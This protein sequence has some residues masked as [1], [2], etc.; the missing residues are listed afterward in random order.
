[1][2]VFIYPNLKKQYSF[3]C[4]QEV[5]KILS[6]LDFNILLTDYSGIGESKTVTVVDSA[7]EAVKN[8]D[9]II[10]IGGDGTILKIAASAA[11]NNKKLLGINCG[12]LGFMASMERGE[13]CYLSK[14]K[15]GSYT[16]ESR[17]MLDA[18]VERPSGEFTA[19]TA[20]NDIVITHGF[21]YNINDFTVLADG[22]TV[23]SLRADG[24]IFST[25]TGASAYSL[26]AGGP[27]I[28]PSMD[29]IEFTQICPHSLFARTMIFS[30][31]KI[32]EVK[33][34]ADG[35]IGISADGKAPLPVTAEDRIYIKRSELR[36][37]LIDI[38]GDNYFKSIGSKLMQ[39]AKEN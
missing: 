39:P 28:E 31:D 13:L 32:I 14:L 15:D 38:H 2:T 5:I 18:V 11:R 16:T 19:V 17:M 23:S 25:P 34:T 26:S 4:M 35:K 6:S 20:L 37:E 29:C 12:R 7:E 21:N 33:Y 36:L 30:A 10:T 9:I 24:L 3:E 27:L 8:C 22:V 1:M